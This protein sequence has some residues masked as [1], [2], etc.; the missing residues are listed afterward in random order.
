MHRLRTESPASTLL[1]LARRHAVLVAF[2]CILCGCVDT[3]SDSSTTSSKDS[4][5]KTSPWQPGTNGSEPVIAVPMEADDP[6][7][8]A[9]IAEA[10]KTAEDARKRWTAAD[11]HGR[12]QWAIKWAAPTADEKIE[13][14]WVQPI[15]WSPFRIEG[16]LKS[17]PRTP[18]AAGKTT[19]Q[20][21]SFPIEELSDWLYVTQVDPRTGQMTT[22]GGFTNKVLEARYGKP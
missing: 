15:S 1:R 20:L 2:I 10:R 16:I 17:E 5:P 8:Q 18:L 7:M 12:T 21:V 11:A 14:V 19:G 4:A 6:D 22:E 9:A 3:G 13:H